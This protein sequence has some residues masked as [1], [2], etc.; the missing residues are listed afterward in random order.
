M[1]CKECGGKGH[2]SDKYWYVV[3]SPKGHPNFGK[4]NIKP[5]VVNQPWSK[6][7]KSKPGGRP[8]STGSSQ[9]SSSNAVVFSPQQQLEQL[10]KMIPSLSN[11]SSK[12]SETDDELDSHFSGMIACHNA[13]GNEQ[14]WIIDSGASDHMTPHLDKLIKA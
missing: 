5:G 1:V 8:R 13:L 6:W 3:G 9:S 7:N 11:Q 2:Y 14:E 4:P 10:M 12:A